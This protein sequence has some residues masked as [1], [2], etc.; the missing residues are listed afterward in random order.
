MGAV[1]VLALCVL[2]TTSVLA[3]LCLVLRCLLGVVAGLFVVAA[4]VALWPDAH[5]KED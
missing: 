2:V 4:G 5:E 3:A 1:R